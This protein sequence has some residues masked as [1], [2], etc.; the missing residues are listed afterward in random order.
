MAKF[1][2]RLF[3]GPE[4][5]DWSERINMARMRGKAGQS[6]GFSEETWYSG[7]FV[8]A[9]REHALCDQ[10]QSGELY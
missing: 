6:Q 1:A 3:G 9:T 2:V 5:V 7:L 8:N 4:A 10:Y